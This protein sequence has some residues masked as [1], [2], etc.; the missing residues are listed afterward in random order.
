AEGTFLFSEVIDAVEAPSATDL[1]LRLRAPFS[2]LFEYLARGDASIRGPGNYGAVPAALGSGPFFPTG[3]EG[4][5]LLL[6][7]SPLITTAD[8]VRCSQLRIRRAGQVGDLDAAFLQGELDIHHHPDE[9]SR[10]LAEARE[11]RVEQSRPRKRM[12]GLALSL[13]APRDQAS[14]ATVEA[15]RDERVRRAV[16]ISLDRAALL[17]SEA[18]I[19]SGP[20]GPAFA[21]DAL[22]PVELEA[23]PLY[24]HAPGEAAKLLAATGRER[25]EL[26]L[27]HSDSPLMLA[28]S[29]RVADQLSASGIIA[30]L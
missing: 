18:G 25:L 2:L 4:N 16:A 7:P 27:S 24:Q 13:L 20:V 19:H 1:V 3:K 10:S 5:D 9:R 26:R 29:Q 15:F 14:L 6:L 12:R 22:P 17:E 11:D 21:G 30:R 8:G 23:H 28:L